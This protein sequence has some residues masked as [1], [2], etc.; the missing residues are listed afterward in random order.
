MSTLKQFLKEHPVDNVTAEVVISER[1]KDFKFKIKAMS[2]EENSKY[3]EQCTKVISNTNIKVD[4]NK[5]MKLVILNHCVEPNFKDA[6]DI[7][8]MGCTSPD[9]YLDKALLAGEQERL[10]VEIR[11]LSGFDISFK[12]IKDEAK[13]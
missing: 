2:N 7:E 10:G 11:K 6:K 5:L 9:E 4:S 12:Q 3:A 8:E 1:L 13:N